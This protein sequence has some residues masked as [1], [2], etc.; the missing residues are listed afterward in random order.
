MKTFKY[1]SN[2]EQ[3]VPFD[4]KITTDHEYE[5]YE[6]LDDEYKENTNC[7]KKNVF[8]DEED[9]S[10]QR[11]ICQIGEGEASVAY[12]IFDERRK[13]VICKKVL[14][15]DEEQI[16]FKDLQNIYK[17][18]KLIKKLLLIKIKR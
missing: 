14:K 1:F 3:V 7:G 2:F 6:A 13:E 5:D 8:I 12:K 9:E 4:P 10:H 15:T 16:T 11:V 18:F 17:I